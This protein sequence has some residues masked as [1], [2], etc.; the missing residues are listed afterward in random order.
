MAMSR[1]TAWIGGG[2]LA[3]LLM[4]AVLLMSVRFV[5]ANHTDLDYPGGYNKLQSY[6]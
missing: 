3:R 4:V 1:R 5:L 6:A 2:L